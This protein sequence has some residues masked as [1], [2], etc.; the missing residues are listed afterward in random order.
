MND[1]NVI[2]NGIVPV[3]EVLNS[4]NAVETIYSCEGHPERNNSSP[5][6]MFNA[7]VDIAFKVHQALDPQE[8]NN[9]LKFDWLLKARFN[10][11]KTMTYIIES[12]DNRIQGPRYWLFKRWDRK[13][14]DA[15]LLKMAEYLKKKLGL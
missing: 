5:Y 14:M 2:E 8:G 1:K 9:P 15:E 4:I 12:N 7:P 10:E 11:D 6:V 3:C 13:A